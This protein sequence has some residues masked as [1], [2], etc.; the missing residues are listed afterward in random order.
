VDL[1]NLDKASLKLILQTSEGF[2]PQ[3][4]DPKKIIQNGEL[5]PPPLGHPIRDHV[6]GASFWAPRWG[7]DAPLYKTKFVSLDAAAT[8]LALLLKTPEGEKK[9]QALAIGQR[10]PLRAD[11]KP[12]F[13]VEAGIKF[14]SKPEVRVIFDRFD[15]ARAGIV[16]TR[17]FA[18]LEA[19]ER[20]GEPY[21]HV[22]TFYPEL[23]DR[24]IA[25][26]LDAKTVPS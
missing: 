8:A 22:Q 16:R 23:N 18:A 25:R 7:R 14:R 20:N 10:E 21:L 15:L 6:R 24:E 4:R 5:C 17:C 9:L 12:A 19:R 13:E 26:L 3:R 2:P 1:K 11:I